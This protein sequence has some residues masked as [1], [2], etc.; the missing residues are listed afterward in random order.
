MAGTGAHPAS[1]QQDLHKASPP[2]QQSSRGGAQREQGW[3]GAAGEVEGCAAGQAGGEAQGQRT[4]GRELW[5]SRA[6]ATGWRG[7]ATGRCCPA[8]A[9]ALLCVGRKAA[10]LPGHCTHPNTHAPAQPSRC[11]FSHGSQTGERN[12]HTGGNNSTES[13]G[14]SPL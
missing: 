14:S 9:P 5:H 13:K 3:E 11:P 1:Q 7:T 6:A 8:A 2:A 10:G 12:S 4:M